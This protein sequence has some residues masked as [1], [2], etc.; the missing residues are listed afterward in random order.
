MGRLR[1]GVVAGFESGFCNS[2]LSRLLLGAL[3]VGFDVVVLC[4]I[5]LWVCRAMDWR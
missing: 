2:R 5:R 4:N 1:F 3:F